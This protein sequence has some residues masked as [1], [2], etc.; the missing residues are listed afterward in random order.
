MTK[1][2]G[3][4][5]YSG[6]SNDP[7][8]NSWITA[9]KVVGIS[10]A[11]LIVLIVIAI[12]CIIGYYNSDR[13]VKLIESRSSEFIDGNIYIGKL[14]YKLFKSYPWLE[15][16]IDTLTLISKSLNNVSPAD[17]SKLPENSDTLASVNF[18]KGK[19]N[20]HDLIHDKIRVKDIVIRQ[21]EINVVMVNDSL[22]N[23]DI[24]KRE[25]AIKKVPDIEIS[26]VDIEAPLDF[27]FFSLQQDIDAFIR[28][29]SF[30]L[31]RNDNKFYTVGFD[32]YATGRY[33][34]YSLPGRIP[35][36]FNTDV[37]LNLP[38]I[39][40]DLDNLSVAMAGL[41]IGAKGKININKD[42]IDLDQLNIDV[43]VN[44]I[45]ELIHS[46]PVQLTQMASLPSGLNGVL[47]V[48]INLSVLSP[49]KIDTNIGSDFTINNLPKMW[50]QVKVDDAE[51]KFV[52][53]QGKRIYANDIYLVASANFDPNDPE[54]T[55]LTV[56]ELRLA[57]EGLNFHG[58]S[59]VNNLTGQEQN[60][61]G[62]F[63]FHSSLMKSLS[64]LLPGSNM[65]VAG[66]LEGNLIFSGIALDLG[67]EGLKN[68]DISGKI[69]SNNL[70]I[71]GLTQNSF[72][73]K[74]IKGKYD[75]KIPAYPLNNYAGLRVDFSLG[76]DSILSKLPSAKIDLA[77]LSI[78]LDAK[79]TISGTPDPFGVLN[80]SLKN[81]QATMQGN[82]L[83]TED[84]KMHIA[85]NLKSNS[86]SSNN[87]NAFSLTGEDELIASRI[88]HTPLVVEYNGGGILQT[89]MNLVSLDGEITMGKGRFKTNS[90]LY[91]IEF[92]GIDVTTNLN[93]L[94][95]KADR[96][97]IDDTS[98]SMLGECDGIMPFMTSYS[99]TPL[100]ASMD[101]RF[102]N[103]DINRLSWGYYG[104]QLANGNDS[105]FYIPAMLP[106]TAADSICVAIP[107]NIEADIRIQSNSAEYM[108]FE[109]SPL[110]TDINVH[111][112][113]AT[114]RNLTIGTPYCTAIVDWTYSTSKLE[115][116][117]MNL[118][119]KVKSFN[120][121]SF[122]KVF[123]DLLSKTPELQN[124]TGQINADFDCNFRM[125]PDM[126][127]NGASLRGDFNIK[128][129]NMQF[130]RQGKIEKITHLMLIEGD[131]PI[132]IEDISITGDYHDNILQ[133][134]PFKIQFDDYQL[135][136]AGIN[137]IDGRM[138]YHLALE[139]SPFHLPF[140]VSVFGSMKHPE[141]RVG[142]THINDYR[143]QQVS[144]DVES[145][146]NVNIMAWLRHGWLMFIQEAAKYQRQKEEGKKE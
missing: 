130:A 140:G 131:A 10:I 19:I 22:A 32:G 116:I 40:V 63:Y 136:I 105:A 16:E 99:A 25:I 80:V 74:N 92:A 137:N 145:K 73:L 33:Q 55:E 36:K 6:L 23:F 144:A 65:K 142:G 31:T 98:F 18:I 106:L 20:I 64:Y 86:N 139:K 134:N 60:I 91:P 133:L 95:L 49:Y 102:D 24:A 77:G 126:F 76:A 48:E 5:N 135:G 125:F 138:Y 45:F 12:W 122:Y 56:S 58:Y 14:D 78:S 8:K 79:D 84:L 123:P 34:A 7:R 27:R 26:E 100:A 57:G 112:G 132:K 41:S 30:Y 88:S 9:L 67:K 111:N 87:S 59:I 3:N 129:S 83:V 89:V 117:F 101:I 108:H 72:R 85:G 47:P 68:I 1:Y 35:I 97:K 114:L 15:F 96:V 70:S 38:L 52:P 93:R 37:K 124:L 119:G 29:E 110:S 71:D 146:I 43:K 107:R 13:I 121:D 54:N 120:F 75:A 50:A 103:V 115:N 44:D 39:S 46:L 21:P 2:Y 53:P 28:L 51:L 61:E 90:Y 82:S 42:I 104:S 94:K 66:Q 81:L 141:I 4:T 118:K 113:A 143:T 69:N 62:E 128:A 109:F 127:I 11:S 17:R